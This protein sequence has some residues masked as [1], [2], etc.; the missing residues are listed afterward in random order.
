FQLETRT[1]LV[2]LFCGHGWAAVENSTQLRDSDRKKVTSLGRLSGVFTPE[3]SV[4]SC[5]RASSDMK[6]LVSF[7]NLSIADWRSEPLLGPGR[8]QDEELFSRVHCEESGCGLWGRIDHVRATIPHRPTDRA[9]GALRRAGGPGV[10]S[11]AGRRF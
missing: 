7:L 1:R 11:A 4:D 6:T 9:A 3:H 8:P 5:Y 2:R 10:G